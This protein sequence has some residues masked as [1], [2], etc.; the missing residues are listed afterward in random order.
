[1]D[2]E[3][4]ALSLGQNLAA[5]LIAAA[6][7]ALANRDSAAVNDNPRLPIAILGG[8]SAIRLNERQGVAGG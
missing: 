4:E 8:R 1:M 3:Q 5:N 6:H 2:L 7:L